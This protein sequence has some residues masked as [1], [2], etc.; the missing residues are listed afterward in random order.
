MS[1]TFIREGLG[2]AKD[3]LVIG[4]TNRDPLTRG[5]TEFYGPIIACP[6]SLADKAGVYVLERYARRDSGDR[7]TIRM[8]CTGHT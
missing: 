2:I 5:K 6:P 7:E 4:V 3:F 8:R 1:T